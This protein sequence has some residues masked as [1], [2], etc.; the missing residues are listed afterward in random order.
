[1]KLF[2]RLFYLGF[3]IFSACI[4]LKKTSQTPLTINLDTLIMPIS[5][6]FGESENIKKY[7]AAETRV[8]DLIHTSLDIRPDFEKKYLNGKANLLF[9]A[10]FYPTETLILDAKGLDINEVSLV[11]DS[12]RKKLKYTYDSLKLTITLDRV[13]KRNETYQI[14]ID[15][16]SKPELL[17]NKGSVAITDTKGLY[18]INA[19]G[20]DKSKPK[21]IWTQGETEYNSA[22]FPTIDSPNERM[23]QEISITVDTS[24]STI[25]NGLMLYSRFN[26]DGTRTDVWKQS[27][28][29]APYLS[30]FAAGKFAVIHD[31]WKNIEVNYY[32]DPEFAGVG[33]KIFGNT[34]EMID[35]FS[36]R[37][38]FDF[39]WE[40]YSEIVV[41]DYVS[42]A[43]E[44]TGAVIFG[45]FMQRN[46]RELID[47][48]NEDVVSHELFHHWFGDL[49]TCES[50]SNLPLNE[51]FATYGEYLWNEHKYGGE[52]ADLGI[53]TDMNAYLNSSAKGK[54]PRLIRF[55]Y[56]DKEDM[57]DNIS[58]QKGG[59]I[60]HM[61]R[62]L[63]GDEAFFQSLKLY[64][65]TNKFTAVEA[66]NLR[67]AFEQVTG[68]DLNWIFNYWCFRKLHPILDFKYE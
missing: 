27:V 62:K 12:S 16:T 3:F 60:L 49:V 61:L 21:Q 8:N 68:E 1:M 41:H 35:F 45:D 6:N 66:Q 50:W 37:L 9:Q 4:S 48:T 23:T 20:K 29:A 34:P 30:M 39:P 63:V 33:K 57:F 31:K 47:K 24:F 53:Q 18:F 52:E 10:Y 32:L 19:D 54:S 58:Y 44:N 22:W 11:S 28:G 15:Y 2:N 65:Q 56:E 59:R 14:F 67:L 42:G 7:R 13:Y 17:R 36:E 40:K 38:G 55:N 5:G 64:V 43:M 46:D 51:S 25:S 26:N